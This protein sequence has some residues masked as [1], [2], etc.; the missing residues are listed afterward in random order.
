[1]FTRT[2]NLLPCGRRRRKRRRVSYKTENFVLVKIYLFTYFQ[3]TNIIIFTLC[4][5]QSFTRVNVP[6][7]HSH[8]F[9]RGLGEIISRHGVD[10][11]HLTLTKG[12][13]NY[14]K[15]GY[16]YHDAGPGAEIST[17]FHRDVAK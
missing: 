2:S 4:T 3:R 15:W 13:W 8:L 12:L 10:E 16:P 6:V 11:L 17:W 1:M 14:Q 5:L 9:P 7:Q